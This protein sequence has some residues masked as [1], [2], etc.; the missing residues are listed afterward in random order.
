MHGTSTRVDSV[1]YAYF[2][3]N[4][5]TPVPPLLTVNRGAK[6]AFI[7]AFLCSECGGG[8]SIEPPIQ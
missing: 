3:K 6:H 4:R 5:L 1:T 8:V 7:E 2:R